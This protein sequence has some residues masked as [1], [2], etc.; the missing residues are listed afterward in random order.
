MRYDNIFDCDWSM[1]RM[2]DVLDRMCN[3]SPELRK[4]YRDHLRKTDPKNFEIYLEW[5]RDLGY[6]FD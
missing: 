3:F 5:E 4:E 6:E 1:W 2:T